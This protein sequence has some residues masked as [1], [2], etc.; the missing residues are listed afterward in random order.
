MRKVASKRALR[1]ARVAGTV[2]T[3]LI[4]VGSL[5]GGAM[6]VSSHPWPQPW[7]MVHGSAIALAGV[8]VLV[9]AW[10]WL[11]QLVGTGRRAAEHRVS[12]RDMAATFLWWAAP[13]LLASPL[14]SQDIY[15]Y[16]A[17]GS[18]VRIGLDPY[19]GGPVDLLGRLN[20]LARNVPPI[21]AHSP[22]PYG[23]VALG[24]AAAISAVTQDAVF[25][26]I[27]LHRAVSV[28]GVL[29]AG[30]ASMHLAR[31]FGV[32]GASA[33]WL[34]LCN[35]LTLLHLIGGIHNEAILLGFLMV[36]LEV[37]CR[38]LERL[39]AGTGGWWLLAASAVL[40]SCAGLVKVTGFIGL[41][42]TGMALAREL[43]ARRGIEDADRLPRLR[44][45]GSVAGAA[46]FQAL[47]LA[48]TTVAA[49]VGTGIG[50]GWMT[51]QGGA[52][53]IRSWLSVTTEIG[54]I[55][56]TVGDWF[57]FEIT[58]TAVHISRIVGI[59]IA[60]M[61]M[62]LLLWR[63]YTGRIRAAGG[64]GVATLIL[65]I[66]FP[67]VQ[68]WY[69]LWAILPLAAWTT[70]PWARMGIAAYSA[71]LSFLVLPPGTGMIA[72]AVITVYLSALAGFLALA[73]VWWFSWRMLDDAASTAPEDTPRT[74]DPP[75][76]GV[77]LASHE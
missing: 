61:C 6:P 71:F 13:L 22:S 20:P 31:R 25:P 9:T 3:V 54:V 14:F 50:L 55:I 36:G 47:I 59:A 57:G 38:G 66:L 63:T 65:V 74:M 73:A 77:R 32:G 41:G 45:V 42:F 46:V 21:W 29:A 76:S 68:P 7:G 10:A 56:G 33:L 52:A 40:I 48:A 15:S 27:L 8:A 34:G 67:V 51:V 70:E 5:G 69:P 72:S 12:T 18:C 30:W 62:A 39:R 4:A 2:G 64:L 28:L 58:D 49:S 75:R 43:A 44:D 16:L 53:E 1:R 24:I 37:H 19:W 17:H 60:L 26:A 23:P 35:P 11:F